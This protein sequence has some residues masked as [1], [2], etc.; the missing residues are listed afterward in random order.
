MGRLEGLV[1]V[2]T[3]AGRGIGRAA[4][5]GFAE[6]GAEVVAAD[7]RAESAEETAR[8]VC[9]GGGVA[10]ALTAD[11][12]KREDAERLMAESVE[13]AGRVD[14][15]VNN[16]GIFPR[17]TVIDMGDDEWDRVLGVNLNGAFY[18]SRAALP[19]MVEAGFGRIVNVT[20]RM[21]LQGVAG[22]AHYAA[23]KAGII[24]FTK[25]LALEVADYGINV[26]AVSPGVT[27][28]PMVLDVND[29]E[30]IA[31]FAQTLPFKRLWE[32]E[33]IVGSILYLVTDDSRHVTG[34]V[35]YAWS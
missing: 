7:I 1:A 5:I 15:L 34:Q 26:N 29:P 11:V 16:A 14:I 10:H 3:G 19:M 31:Q 6:E 21:A 2:I 9:A 32:P 30:W 12:S 20:S 27:A 4:A 33:D 23:A 25:S 8:A 35:V 28:T 17:A 22:G 18:C 13:K 24:G